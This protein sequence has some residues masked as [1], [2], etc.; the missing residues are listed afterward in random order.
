LN[1]KR[2]CCCWDLEGPISII[3]F[4]AKLGKELSKKSELNLHKY[5]MGEFFT[6][7]SNYDDY[8]IDAPGVKERLNI[9]EYQPGDTLRL[10]APLYTSCFT[11]QQL[12][13][14][15]KNDL[16]LL[17]GCRELMEILQKDWDIFIIST[18]YTHFAH[19]VTT[20]LG[21]P[22]DHVYCT[23]LNIQKL[24]KDLSNIKA[25]IN[26]IIEK[27]F[28]KYLINS[29]NLSCVIEDLNEF[30]WLGS[31]SD[32]IRVMN[33][34]IV[35]GG[36]RKELAIEEISKRTDVPISE[37]IA[38]GD[39]ITD[40]NMLERIKQEDGISISFNGNKF[41][42]EHANVAVTTTNSLGVLPIF[43]EKQD[44]KA[45]LQSWEENFKSFQNN[46]HNIPN[47]LLSPE[48]KNLFIKYNFLPEIV[49]LTNKSADQLKEIIIKQERM[50]KIVRGW[51]GKLY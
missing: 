28:K 37:M 25:S 26:I 44:F 3:D 33:Q 35:R 24:K 40:I 11:D 14:L 43:Q 50:R 9:P 36:K 39:S 21:I 1:N 29:R 47:S 48:C 12:I 30:F 19:N 46:P 27:I 10:M 34:V 20:A 18:S 5:N 45:F 38:L 31:K 42:I 41:S 22:K 8:L 23:D 49:D 51:A 15:A 16:G 32:Y 4:A 7:I 17:P 13:S 2:F 6:M